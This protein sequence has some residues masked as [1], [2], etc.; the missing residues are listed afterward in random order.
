MALEKNG[1]VN[2]LHWLGRIYVVKIS[3]LLKMIYRFDVILIKVSMM[4]LAE[5]EQTMLKLA[6]HPEKQSW[7]KLE[8]SQ[9][10]ISSHPVNKK[11]WDCIKIDTETRRE[12]RSWGKP[13]QGQQSSLNKGTKNMSWRATLST[14]GAGKTGYPLAVE[15]RNSRHVGFLELAREEHVSGNTWILAM[16]KPRK[17]LVQIKTRRPKDQ[18]SDF[19]KEVV[20][21]KQITWVGSRKISLV[22]WKKHMFLLETRE[23]KSH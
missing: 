8:A 16:S 14:N 20:S 23:R 1:S 2:H 4:F 12:Y 11:V 13:L 7:T 9:Y 5:V 17:Q 19:E 18:K 15:I 10:L 6:W 21:V 22:C 3:V